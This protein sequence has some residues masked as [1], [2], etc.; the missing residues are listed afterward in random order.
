MYVFC[1][2][3]RSNFFNR[4]SIL[5][6][7]KTLALKVSNV[8]FNDVITSYKRCFSI[9]GLILFYITQLHSIISSYGCAISLVDKHLPIHIELLDYFLFIVAYQITNGFFIILHH[10]NILFLWFRLKKVNLSIWHHTIILLSYLM[11]HHS[12]IQYYDSF[13]GEVFKY[14]YVVT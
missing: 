9:F 1:S 11:L 8:I 10:N 4:I 3:M 6:P 5:F 2:L 12:T 7:T 13:S 14:R